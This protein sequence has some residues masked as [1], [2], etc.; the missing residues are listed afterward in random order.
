V[1]LIKYDLIL[2]FKVL[3]WFVASKMPLPFNTP[4]HVLINL[5]PCAWLEL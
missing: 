2:D 3:V 5:E 4:S 1:C